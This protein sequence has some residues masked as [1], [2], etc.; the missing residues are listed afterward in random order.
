MLLFV[1]PI[2]AASIIQQLFHSADTAVVGRFVGKEALAAVGGTTPLVNLFIE[3]FVGLS[4]AANVV[5]ARFIGQ[6]DKKRAGD[7]VHTAISVALISGVIVGAAGLLLSKPMLRLMLVPEDIIG[8]S[9]EYLRIYFIGMP[10]LMLNN[11]S[12]AVFRSRGNTQKPLCCLSVGGI[13]NVGLNLFFVLV[14]NAGVAGVAWATVIS[15]GVSSALLIFLLTREDEIVRLSPGKLRIDREILAMLAKIGLPSGFLGSVFS[16]SNVCTQSAINSLGTDAVSASSAAVNVEIYLQFIGN[17]F[18]QATTTAVS[19][20]YGAKKRDRCVSV[21][22]TALLL[23][24]SATIVL[25]GAV[26]ISGR[27]L[28]RIFVTDAAVIEI[29]MTR[30]KYTVV[31]K[32]VQSVMDIMSG[33]LQGYGYT[34]VPAL[35]SVF[36]VCGVRLF[37]IFAVFPNYRTLGSL[38]VIYPVTQAIA[39][40]S[41]TIAAWYRSRKID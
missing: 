22:K 35:I 10:F 27:R 13:V 37:W 39:A 16:I 19:Q 14:L 8:L 7:A 21:I 38:M 31:F 18:A 25:S 1:L 33:G 20:N 24:V 3:F 23:C 34:L 5:V 36:G 17:A 28:L 26:Y 2:A 30:M 4:N 15:S 9:A 40:V 11:F 29:A 12:S 41:Y 6:G 32:F